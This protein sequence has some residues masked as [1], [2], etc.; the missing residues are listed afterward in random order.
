MRH[1]RGI[2]ARESQCIHMYSRT[3]AAAFPFFYL[4]PSCLQTVDRTNL[5][6]QAKSPASVPSAHP[7]SVMQEL[8]NR[9]HQ[10]PLVV[11]PADRT[12]SPCC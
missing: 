1:P 12:H 8:K 6:C 5:T 7:N 4:E 2:P 11:E 3:T 9:P 10:H